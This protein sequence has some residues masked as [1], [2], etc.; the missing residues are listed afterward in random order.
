MNNQIYKMAEIINNIKPIE[1]PIGHRLQGKGIYRA[2]KIAE[3]LYNNGCRIQTTGEW[4]KVCDKSPR[5]IC[6]ICAHLYNNR[7]YKYCP[8]CGA[9]MK[10]GAE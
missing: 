2:T 6:T 7:E 8:F 1:F 9:K 3:H 4:K 10:G 5:Y